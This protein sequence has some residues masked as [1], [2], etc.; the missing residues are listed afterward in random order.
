M[1]ADHA[2]SVDNK[3]SNPNPLMSWDSNNKRLFQKF[4]RCYSDITDTL[5]PIVLTLITDCS[6]QASTC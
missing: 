2:T 1:K 4:L 5:V 3:L 6:E